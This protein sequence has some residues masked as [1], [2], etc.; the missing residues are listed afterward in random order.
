M[1]CEGSGKD[2]WLSGWMDHRI[3]VV[4]GFGL[5]LDKPASHSARK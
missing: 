2:E 5:W 4:L 1:E 3:E